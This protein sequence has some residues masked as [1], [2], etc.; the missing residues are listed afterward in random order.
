MNLRQFIRQLPRRSVRIGAPLAAML[1][2]LTITTTARAQVLYGSITGNVTDSSGAVVAGATVTITHKETGQ[3]RDGVTDANGGYD[4]P[5]LQ[6]GT[7]SIKVGK[8]GFKTVTKEN[9][10]VTLNTVTRADISIEVGQVTENVL[11]TADAAQLKTDRAEVSSELTSRPLRD[12][13]VALG[14]N[15]QNLFRT[16]PGITPPENAHSIPSNPSR[17]LV[18][19]VNGAS[20]SSNNTRIDGV[21]T[22]NVWLPHVTAYVPALESIETVNVVTNSFDAEQGLAGGAA[23]NVQI[24]SGTNDFHG[25]AFEYHANHKLN[26]KN[27][28]TPPDRDKNKFLQ[29][30]YG[31]TFG[32]PIK[33]DKL[34]FFASYEGTKNRQNDF[35]IVSVPTAALRAGDFSN[36][37]TSAGVLVPIYDST[38]SSDPAT[39][40]Q[41]RDPLRAT[42][43]NPLG[44]NIIPDKSIDPIV[45][46]ILPL[47]PLPNLPGESN[48]YYATAPF[49]FDRWTI[50]SKVNWTVNQKFNFWGRYS[51]LN[52]FTVNETI[53]G[54]ALQGQAI[55]SSNP[56]TGEGKTHNISFG[57]VYTFTPHF[58]VDA[59]FG[60]VR[61]NTSVAQSDIGE[62]RGLDFLGIPGTN[63]SRP[64]EGGFPFFDL[65]T[66]ADYG[67][68]DTFMPY[69]RSDD[70]YQYV[71][72]ATWLKGSHN[73]R[74]GGDVY[75][76]LLNHTQPEFSGGTS[77][78]AR[79]GF[80]FAA[81]VT[82]LQNSTIP[83]GAGQYNSFAAFLLGAP[84]GRG[85]LNLTVAP[86]NTR[87]WQYSLYVRD[88]WQINPR[89]SISY[90]TRWEYFPVPTRA[91][92]GLERYNIDTNM[93]EIGGVGDVP[94]DLGVKVSKRLFAPRIGIAYRPT[95]TFVIRAGYGI[96]NDPYA[97]ARPM[98]TNHPVLINFNQTGANSFTPVITGLSAGI[99]PV[100]TPDLG[101]GIIPVPSG[102]SVVTLPDEFK[103]GYVQSWN[104]T[105]QKEL[106][107][108]FVGEAGYV[109]T[110]QIRQLGLLDQ[111]W[112]PLGTG[113][114]GRQLFSKFGRTAATLL[115]SPVGGSHYDSL[116]TRLTRQFAKGYQISA[117]Y[118][119]SKSIGVGGADNSDNE[120][121][122][123][124]PQ[125]FD[126]NRALSGFDRT[127]S[128]Q[129]TN[130]IELPF[131]KGRKWLS[132]GGVLSAIAGGWQV[133]NI[134]SIQSGT[135]FRVTDSG[136][137]LNVDGT[138]DQRPDMVKSEVKILGGVGPRQ[139]YF[140]T[141]AFQAVPNN[142][143][144]FGTAGWSI[145]RGPGITTWDFG[146]FRRF[147]VT[148]RF[149]LQFRAEAFNFT[150]TPIF[151]NPQG[152]FTSSA[153]GEISSTN[154][155]SY[156]PNRQFRFGLRIG[157]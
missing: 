75:Y 89:L 87:N 98:R 132:G 99:P 117:N 32:G 15:Y 101:N 90:G 121:W 141:T 149:D 124:I 122:I 62:N 134:V 47:I 154:E 65:D 115:V 50:D 69:T 53:F 34:F 12:L 153:F 131:G 19:N 84:Q 92:R 63:G 137:S 145:L 78:G 42:A 138:S 151:S 83:A 18:F 94:E 79:G 5:T 31:G 48:N 49:L 24:K 54:K 120:P 126:L 64:F 60:F 70:Q 106:K 118:T 146:L 21:S 93:M 17:A 109:A 104:L 1:V 8:S 33:K 71:A 14:R 136:T 66:Y 29:N 80:N 46:K 144:R 55:N 11:I 156:A 7:Y 52:F 152:S 25:S 107:W 74:F 76:Q 44:L 57:G 73:I 40:T 128:F 13:P 103:R 28:F 77:V 130:L 6:A 43:A 72:N 68:V 105:L 110:R 10:A 95:Q 113:Q 2:A 111:N 3:S 20:R 81:G 45:K 35:R 119:W 96:T 22:T 123:K 39:R 108:G 26:A 112:A 27:F 4:F 88:Q 59:N 157:F 16:L 36:A 127:H 23:I 102:V 116:Q 147:Q 30:Q 148:E 67:T 37:R 82:Q 150:N 61:M 91:D 58:I 133:N 100:A 155:N 97:L 143:N 129:L 140:D 125:F 86:Y 142:A 139:K 38:S 56:G 51:I 85:K 135:P 9:V 114:K 41:I